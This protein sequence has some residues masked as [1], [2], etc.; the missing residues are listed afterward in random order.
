MAYT[1]DD[2]PLQTYHQYLRVGHQHQPGF[3]GQFILVIDLGLKVDHGKL[4]YCR[5]LVQ[6]D[7]L[8]VLLLTVVSSTEMVGNSIMRNM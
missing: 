7:Q 1:I 5:V 8:L 4:K 3:Y 2:N 6:V